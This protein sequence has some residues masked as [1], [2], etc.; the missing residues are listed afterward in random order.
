MARYAPSGTTCHTT[1]AMASK[2][3]QTLQAACDAVCKVMDLQPIEVKLQM[4]LTRTMRPVLGRAHYRTRQISLHPNLTAKEMMDTLKHEIAHFIAYDL[5]GHM[6]HGWIWR[7]HAKAL[8][9]DPH[10]I[11]RITEESAYR[12]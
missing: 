3:L 2:S 7:M 5:D 10:A 4:E 9:C 12:K 6:G 11:R 1:T 8:G